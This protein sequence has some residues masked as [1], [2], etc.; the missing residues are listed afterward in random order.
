VDVVVLGPLRIRDDHGAAVPVPTGRGG[1]LLAALLVHAGTVVSV[2]ALADYVWNQDPPRQ[3]RA[4]VQTM[5]TRLRQTLGGQVAAR[6]RTAAPGYVFDLRADELDLR[7]FETLCERGHAAY[8]AADWDRAAGVFA[9]A[10]ELWRGEPLAG[11][12]SDRLRLEIGAPLVER[13]LEAVRCRNEVELI[14]GRAAALLPTLTRLVEA[15]PLRE[16]FRGQLMVALYRSGRVADALATFRHGRALLIDQLGVEPGSELTTLHERILAGDLPEAGDSRP[17]PPVPPPIA[18]A[19][20]PPDIADFT[21]R[22]DYLQTL[23]DALTGGDGR[24]GSAAATVVLA[25]AGGMGKTTLALRAAHRL[26]SRFPDGQLYVNLQGG[27]SKPVRA[28]DVHGRF[29]R[30][31]GVEGK[32]IPVDLDE[33]AALYRSMLADRRM[34]LVLDDAADAAQVRP[35]LP[36]GAGHAV[37]VTSRNRLSGLESARHVHLDVLDTEDAHDLFVHVVGRHRAAAEPAATAD[38][39]RLCAGLPLALRIAG[40]RL[41]ARPGWAIRDLADRLGEGTRRLDEL[42]ADDLTVRASFEV[43][44]ANLPPA[45]STASIGPAAAFLLLGLWSGPDLSTVAAAALF[46]VSERVAEDVLESLVDTHLLQTPCPGRYRLHDLL[47]VYALDQAAKTGSTHDHRDAIR[48]LL[49]WYLASAGRAMDL[50]SPARQRFPLADGVPFGPIVAFADHRD[51]MDWCETERQNLVAAVSAAQAEGLDT[52]A[53]RLPAELLHF[54]SLRSHWDDWITTYRAGLDSARRQRDRIAE[55][56]MLNGLGVAYNNV[57]RYDDAL[58]L[59]REALTIARSSGDRH[60]EA[61]TMN[62]IA[63]TFHLQGAF[64]ESVEWRL[65]SLPVRREIGHPQGVATTL[66]NLGMAYA[67]Q[68]KHDQAIV[69]YEQAL[70]VVRRTDSRFTEASILDSLGAAA[71]NLGDTTRAIDYLHRA[72]AIKRDIG[73]RS[74]QAGTLE[75]LAHVLLAAGRTAEARVELNNALTVLG[76]IEGSQAAGIR[77]LLGTLEP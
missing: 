28:G 49:A 22:A 69:Y 7:R 68:G 65:R 70:D 55:T 45:T 61:V 6:I 26:R 3:V 13:H 60:G 32:A 48:R 27:R 58:T 77:E 59:F 33:R 63:S 15:H 18:P 8:A 10:L 12:D 62:N 38:V 9:E 52:I 76:D 67:A 37:L 11:V 47:R 4:A 1:V 44:Y 73:E 54:F 31:L 24:R 43:S 5:L 71:G 19:Q 20:L 17:A 51:A 50:I 14:L 75:T 23:Y 39:L 30:D 25:G 72:I 74:G 40:A 56:W 36:A 41:A 66:N 35:L 29:L 34:L 2:D 57:G 64:E 53:W 21:G 42:R 16:D 46:G